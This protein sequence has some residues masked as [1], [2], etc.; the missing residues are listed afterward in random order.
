MPVPYPRLAPYWV[1]IP[2]R[3]ST[4]RDKRLAVCILEPAEVT[5]EREGLCAWDIG[6]LDCRRASV[7]VDPRREEVVLWRIE[8]PDVG[9]YINGSTGRGRERVGPSDCGTPRD[10]NTRHTINE[11]RWERGIGERGGR[12]SCRMTEHRNVSTYLGTCPPS[13][14]NSCLS[15][16]RCSTRQTQRHRQRMESPPARSSRRRHISVVGKMFAT[17]YAPKPKC[18]RSQFDTAVY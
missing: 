8:V 15:R 1:N 5:R 14:H 11:R 13:R 12:M 18:R 10:C 3:D 4:Y 16:G 2:V 17:C 9:L 6:N 7:G